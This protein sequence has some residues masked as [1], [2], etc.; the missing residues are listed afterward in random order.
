MGIPHQECIV[1]RIVIDHV[2]IPF[3]SIF[4]LINVTLQ[5]Q[6][7][8]SKS[9]IWSS[10]VLLLFDSFSVMPIDE[11]LIV[12]QGNFIL[13]DSIYVSRIFICVIF[14]ILSEYFSSFGIFFLLA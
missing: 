5:T 10:Y 11:P 4:C 1:V 13:P 12:S 9:I 6:V 2:T 7:A 8:K 14:N 3:Y